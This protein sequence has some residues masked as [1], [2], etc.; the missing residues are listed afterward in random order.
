MEDNYKPNTILESKNY[1]FSFKQW[2][3]L[4]SEKAIILAVHGYNDYSNSFKTPATFLSKFGISTFAIDL[5]GFGKNND[6]GEW[7]PLEIHMQDVKYFLKKL[8]KDNKDK[9]IFILGESMGG[10]I[11]LSTILKYEI[12]VDGV[13]LIAP[14]IWN[15]SEKNKIKSVLLSAISKLLPNLKIRG[16]SYVSVKPSNNQKMLKELSKDKLFIHEPKL[17]SMNGIVKLMDES[18]IYA[19]NYFNNLKSRTLLII[20]AIDEIV[21]RKPLME[22]LK[23]QE[24]KK[25]IEK[26]L[27]IGLYENN[28]HMILR[29][30]NGDDI[31]R[32]IKEWIYETKNI[33]SL[34][35]FTNSIERLDKQKFYHIIEK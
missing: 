28:Y 14:A 23:T 8:K 16:S 31:T 6:R 9:K 13:I 30:I 33:E 26:R 19:K 21:P 35:S 24:A 27:T 4:N 5:R 20:P 29:D 10:A 7:Y 12:H 18:F 11:V 15:F 17:R 25:N 32:E 2:D 3:A 34:Y 22:I 1:N